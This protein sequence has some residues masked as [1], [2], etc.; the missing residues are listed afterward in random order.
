LLWPGRNAVT[1]G[2]GGQDKTSPPASTH[3]DLT[4]WRQR[5]ASRC[6]EAGHNGTEERVGLATTIHQ[7]TKRNPAEGRNVL[8]ASAAHA[9]R[10][11]VETGTTFKQA[12]RARLRST[13]RK[14]KERPRSAEAAQLIKMPRSERR[15]TPGAWAI[16]NATQLAKTNK[17]Q[18]ARIPMRRSKTCLVAKTQWRMAL[19]CSQ[20]RVLDRVRH[21][22]ARAAN[23]P[24]N[25]VARHRH[26]EEQPES[27]SKCPFQKIRRGITANA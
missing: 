26:L 7:A 5:N 9:S 23:N 6:H 8:A 11:C 13:K 17:S 27:K 1:D 15:Q 4:V 24:R 19:L 14:I 12:R 2:S 18:A 25:N 22:K 16:K 20:V 10:W 21:R 3:N